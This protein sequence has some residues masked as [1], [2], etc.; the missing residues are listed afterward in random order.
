MEVARIA[1][2]EGLIASEKDLLL[3]KFY[4]AG[5]LGSRLHETVTAR[6]SKNPNWSYYNQGRP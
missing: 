3:P 5:D 4:V 6:L 1:E 2:Q